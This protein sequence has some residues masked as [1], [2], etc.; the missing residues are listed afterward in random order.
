MTDPKPRPEEVIFDKA[1]Q[2]ECGSGRDAY[3]QRACDNDEEL[4][5][6]VLLLLKHHNESAFLDR[7][8]FGEQGAPDLTTPL[9]NVGTTIDRYK[10]LE[11]IGEG[12]M[13]VV[14]MAEQEKPIRRK[15]AL[16][17]IKLG[18]DTKQVIARFEAERQAL[19]MMDHPN[20]AKVLDA[21]A[22]DTGRP[23]FV[24]EL[25]TGVSITEYCDKNSL[26]TKERLDLFIQV[27]NAIHHAHQKG[28]IH[29][30][31]KPTNIMVA[32]HEGKPVP[33]VID[34]GIAKA[35]NQRL[36]EK[37]LF[38]RYAHIIGTPAYMSPE[39]AEL[40]DFDIDTRSDIYS[41]GV[42]LY[43]LLTGT[44]PFSEEDL[45]KSGYIEMTRV[46][47]EEEPSKPSTKLSTLG[48]TLTDIAKQHGCTPDLLERAVRGD[49][50]WIVMKTL[51]KVRDRRYDHVSSL[52]LDVQRH[53]D[54]RPILA[55]APRVMY[56]LK[57]FIRRHRTQAAMALMVTML[58]LALIAFLSIW[59][60]N[61]Q[62]RMREE[63][64]RH[65]RT[66]AEAERSFD[67]GDLAQ[68]LMQA[69]ALLDSKHV[70]REAKV[71]IDL[72]LTRARDKV[73][74]YTERIEST[75]EA[76]NDY[77]RRAQYRE[78]LGEQEK[79][80]SDMAQY[81]EITSRGWSSDLRFG[82]PENLG[83][84]INSPLN[85]IGAS[86]SSDGLS[87][88][89]GRGEIPGYGDFCMAK[90]SSKDAAWDVPT[91]YGPTSEPDLNLPVNDVT[92]WWTADGLEMP[93]G[94]KT[95]GGYGGLDLWMHKRESVDDKWGAAE[96]LGPVVNGA[97]DERKPTISRDGLELYFDAYD[98]SGG[99]GNWDLW[100]TRRPTRDAPWQ[101]PENLG[102]KVNSDALDARPCLSADG[103]MLFFDSKRLGG[104]GEADLYVTRRKTLSDPWEEAMNLGPLVN[105]P[106]YEEIAYISADCSTLYFDSSRPDGYGGQDI[107]RTPIFSLGNDLDHDKQRA[108]ISELTDKNLGI[109]D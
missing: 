109:E 74:H 57:K 66:M 17:I 48:E 107:W 47:R 99:H 24:M 20:I 79:V 92:S 100:V 15:V 80:Q 60:H 72:I 91:S 2:I 64:V 37:T 28:I 96:N 77:F 22:T 89:F 103:L 98:R 106:A 101:K 102:G 68:S 49:L 95:S 31:I 38:T 69:T 82:I 78:L 13:A 27:C 30:D 8:I 1:I 53:L 83:S 9:E 6:A 23:Y 16:K 105:T 70:K 45:R 75:P 90:R 4:L 63:S 73:D 97:G 46:I 42:V 40:S 44:T 56:R 33:K 87:L 81:T 5:S 85:D 59:S 7:P 29:R 108:S 88:I 93:C 58:G 32:Q 12:G 18:M 54:D 41:L 76:A 61:Q 10:L 52:A 71:L 50:D 36:T 67:L 55:R 26:R 39:Q 43:E 19:A 3:V 14:Y 11:M 62:Q 25:V 84:I 104:Y 34:F 65:K 21:G 86:I 51:E 94:Y 35:T